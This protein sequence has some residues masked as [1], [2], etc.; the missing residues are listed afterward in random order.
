MEERRDG[1]SRGAP[2]ARADPGGKRFVGARRLAREARSGGRLAYLPD[3]MEASRADAGPGSLGGRDALEEDL[4]VPKVPEIADAGPGS[5]GGADARDDLDDL[6]VFNVPEIAETGPESFRAAA[7]LPG[8]ESVRAVPGPAPA[9][10][11]RGTG[12]GVGSPPQPMRNAG[13]AAS[14]VPITPR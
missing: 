4:E 2:G 9:S 13:S 14:S 6:E 3:F 5:L 11:G 8:P 1:H 10:T 12:A 7:E